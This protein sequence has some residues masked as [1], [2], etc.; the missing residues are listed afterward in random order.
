MLH[1][2]L[3]HDVPLEILE[4]PNLKKKKK[5]FLFVEFFFFTLMY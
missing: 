3:I 2:H 5:L 4:K 1:D